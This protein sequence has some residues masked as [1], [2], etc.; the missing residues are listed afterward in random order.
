LA[1][2]LALKM[3]NALNLSI[4]GGKWGVERRKGRKKREKGR[5]WRGRG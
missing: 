3:K 2:A 5:K 4:R 1:F